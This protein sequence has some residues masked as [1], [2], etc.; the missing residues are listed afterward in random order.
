[1]VAPATAA[2]WK[3]IPSSYLLCENDRAIPS[4]GQEDMVNRAKNAGAEVEVTRIKVSNRRE[5]VS[6][7]ML[8]NAQAGHSPFL[9]Q[10]DETVKWI[11]G[12]CGEKL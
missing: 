6:S 10:P 3:E 5:I 9:S 8:M 2:S 12:V 1:M 4:A 7:Y 11:R